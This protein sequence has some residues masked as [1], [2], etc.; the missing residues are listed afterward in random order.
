MTLN[1]YGFPLRVPGLALIPAFPLEHPAFHS[2]A[3]CAQLIQ[4]PCP[5]V[6]GV[7]SPKV[8]H[9][10]TNQHQ[11]FLH[12]LLSLLR[13]D[14][15][16]SEDQ[17]GTGCGELGRMSNVSPIMPVC[18]CD[19]FTPALGKHRRILWCL[20]EA[21]CKI[22]RRMPQNRIIDKCVLI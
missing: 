9:Y 6:H 8:S 13:T 17:S 16:L 19:G 3:A 12:C 11:Q 14:T 4:S 20:H 1:W 21:T 5:A 22:V 10:F 18:P 15:V 2:S 7:I